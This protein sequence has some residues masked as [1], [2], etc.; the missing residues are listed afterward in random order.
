M[1]AGLPASRT[2]RAG[3]TTPDTLV[4]GTATV[5]LAHKTCIDLIVS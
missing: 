1:M 4:Y 3:T 2:S 5:L